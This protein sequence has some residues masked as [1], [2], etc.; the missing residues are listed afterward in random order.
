RVASRDVHGRYLFKRGIHEPPATRLLL[1]YFRLAPQDVVIDV[2][3]NVGYF[4]LLAHRCCGPDVA[5]HAFEAEPNNGALLRDNLRRN[6]ATS[7]VVHELAVSDREGTAELFLYKSSNRGKHSLVPL[8]DAQSVEVETTTLDAFWERQGL[9][10]RVPTLIKM[11]IEGGEY[12]AFRG[13]ESVLARCSFVMIEWS[14]KFLR[15][16]EVSARSF[17][18]RMAAVGL[19]PC[20]ITE[21]GRL[22]RLA[23]EELVGLEPSQNIALVRPS[24]E[25]SEWIDQLMASPD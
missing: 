10:T 1:R 6:G 16:A 3:G 7:V 13:A 22:V 11:D 5:I 23:L 24:S 2:G 19:M 18:E 25:N 15:R 17:A 8:G 12:A 4:S 21:D 14:P 20:R 9:G